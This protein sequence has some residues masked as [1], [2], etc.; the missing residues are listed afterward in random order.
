MID[1]TQSTVDFNEA[2]L[3]STPPAF[4]DETASA[5]AKPVQP[6]P[7]GRFGVW[8]QRALDAGPL[9]TARRKA[10]A[11][12]LI[13]GL[14]LGILGGAMLAKVGQ[15][16]PD[17]P[18]PSEEAIAETTEAA[19]VAE[20]AEPSHEPAALDGFANALQRSGRTSAANR[21]Y[22]L[23]TRVQPANRAYRVAVIR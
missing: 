7:K 14:A 13:S 9:L 3:E 4:F 16:A 22:R 2:K 6:I 17:V 19:S 20:N 21:R 15:S 18:P 8:V 11:L 10:L 23:R 1:D 5:N 12:V